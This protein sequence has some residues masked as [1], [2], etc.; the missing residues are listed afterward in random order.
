MCMI[1]N[2]D[3]V[4]MLA[5]AREVRARKAHRCDEC[6]R[7]IE[8]GE[9]YHT[10]AFVFEG[11]SQTHKTCAHCWVVRQWLIDECGGMVYGEVEE[12][13]RQHAAENPRHY[14]TELLRAVVGMGRHWRTRKGQLMPVPRS[15]RTS[16]EL[17][18]AREAK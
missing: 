18:A 13:A 15:I 14:G 7:T 10:E 16:Y 17:L 6:R 1:D 12:D 2:A 3:R 5:D 11:E 9:T 4:T 8:P